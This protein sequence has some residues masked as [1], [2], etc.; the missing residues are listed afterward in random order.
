[1]IVKAVNDSIKP[2]GLILTL[3]VFK[4]YIKISTKDLPA[5]MKQ[6]K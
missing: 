3:L 1:M 2:K 6:R 4:I 5:A